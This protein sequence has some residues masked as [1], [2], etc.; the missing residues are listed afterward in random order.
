[1]YFFLALSRTSGTTSRTSSSSAECFAA[2]ASFLNPVRLK[3]GPMCFS[4]GCLAFMNLRPMVTQPA[5]A[6]TAKQRCTKKCRGIQGNILWTSHTKHS[7]NTMP[8]DWAKTN[9]FETETLEPQ[10][11][12]MNIP[13]SFSFVIMTAKLLTCCL[14]CHV[15]VPIFSALQLLPSFPSLP[16][17]FPSLPSLPF[18]HCLPSCASLWLL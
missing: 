6:F 11:H 7:T 1:M 8:S 3:R 18:F 5:G 16:S 14:C 2:G 9:S 4:R 13:L 12:T 10:C 17:F 15:N